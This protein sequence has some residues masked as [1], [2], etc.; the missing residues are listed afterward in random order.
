MI[1]PLQKEV[2]SVRD[3]FTCPSEIYSDMYQFFID[4]L[5]SDLFIRTS[6]RVLT[7]QKPQK[8][9]TMHFIYGQE[10]HRLFIFAPTEASPY[11]HVTI[12]R[13]FGPLQ[14]IEQLLKKEGKIA[15]MLLTLGNILEMT[16][17]CGY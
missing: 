9:K 4:A 1:N 14:I 16:H 8:L 5:K 12:Y 11:V 2:L 15:W 13:D 17:V 3:Q 6:L 7:I 10:F